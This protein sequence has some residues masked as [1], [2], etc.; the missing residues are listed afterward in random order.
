MRM[1]NS[2]SCNHRLFDIRQVFSFTGSLHIRDSNCHIKQNIN[3]LTQES[4]GNNER[5]HVNNLPVG[6]DTRL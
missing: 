6:F 5:K 1:T 3:E 4:L 2:I